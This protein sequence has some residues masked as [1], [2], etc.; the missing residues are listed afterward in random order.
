M[1]SPGASIRVF[2]A[3]DH[4]IVTDGLVQL[5][6]LHHEFEV[7]GTCV[8]GVESLRRILELRPD[9][10]ILD[11]SM[12]GMNGLEIAAQLR[13]NAPAVAV[14]I[15]SMH[16]SPEY[17]YRALEVGVRGYLRK[18]SAASEIVDAI[19]AAHAGRRYLGSKIGEIFA[20]Q[21]GRPTGTVKLQSLSVRERVVLGLVVEGLSSTKIGGIMK[22]SP[23]TI[24]TYRSR[25]MQKLGVDNVV[26]LLK[27]AIQNGVIVLD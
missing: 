15:L 4:P 19:R 5:V 3:D 9:V 2:I 16:S 22:L 25:L 10:A 20:R 14:V 13:E 18:E 8:E 27:F 26:S 7:V 23:K 12:P 24:D 6:Q 17:V 11:I 21:A 1:A